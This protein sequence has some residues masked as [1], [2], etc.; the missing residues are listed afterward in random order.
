MKRDN[1]CPNFLTID[2]EE[3]YHVNYAGFDPAAYVNERTNVPA[4]VDRLL[5]ICADSA[6]RCTYFVLGAIGEKYP[7]VVRRIHQA[8]H[9]VASHGSNHKSVHEMSRHEL[10]ADVQRSCGVLE[11]LTGAKV[12]GFRAPSFSV[13]HDTLPRFYE[14]L[15][16]CGLSYSSSVF[17]GRTFL[18]GVPGFP[19]H[20]HRPAVR[21]RRMGIVEFPITGFDLFGVRFPL[22]LRLLSAAALRWRVRAENRHGR[23]A[24]LYVHPREIDPEG[25]RLPIS[26]AQRLVHY[27]GVGGCEAKLRRL[28]RRDG[29]GFC[30]MSEYLAAAELDSPEMIATADV[31]HR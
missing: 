18:Y 26:R 30:T 8:G 23:P 4:L 9:E 1:V 28:L 17:P 22:Y 15:Q 24:V 16:A 27:W 7:E 19:R 31:G 11:S 14:T 12:R 10:R 25:P 13:D 2:V 29:M 6:I 5:E 20:P 21:G 3:Y